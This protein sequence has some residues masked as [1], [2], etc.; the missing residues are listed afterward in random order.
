M[1]FTALSDVLELHAEFRGT[2]RK[3][4]AFAEPVSPPAE[5]RRHS[6]EFKPLEVFWKH[7]EVKRML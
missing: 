6:S 1:A 7:G 4:V 2:L 3:V 5:L